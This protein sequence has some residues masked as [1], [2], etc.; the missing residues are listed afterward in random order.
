[1]KK[2]TS[3]LMFSFLL[4]VGNLIAQNNPGRARSKNSSRS[5]SSVQTETPQKTI[6]Q[7]TDA[8]TVSPGAPSNMAV[9][10]PGVPNDKG[11]G[12]APVRRSA[13]PNNSG[14]SVPSGGTSPHQE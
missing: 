10:E 2:T 12:T 1:M 6:N 3:L 9:K 8:E 14:T 7:A 13:A 5:K 11:K 4:I